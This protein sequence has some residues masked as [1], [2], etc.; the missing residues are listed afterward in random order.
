MPATDRAWPEGEFFGFDRVHDAR[1]LGYR[2]P[3]F[4]WST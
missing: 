4:S 1:T 2:G 3:T